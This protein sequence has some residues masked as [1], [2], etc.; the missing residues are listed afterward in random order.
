MVVD[1]IPIRTA[2]VFP[3]FKTTH[4]FSKSIFI[5]DSGIG[6][7]DSVHFPKNGVQALTQQFV[8][9]RRGV[10]HYS[11]NFDIFGDNCSWKHTQNTNP[12]KNEKGS[13]LV[14]EYL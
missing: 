6:E 9:M 11:G 5:V 12:L 8:Q 2:G 7:G 10:P 13:Q 4:R 3:A 14:G 1:A